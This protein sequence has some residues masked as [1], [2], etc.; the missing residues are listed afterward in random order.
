MRLCFALLALLLPAA[1]AEI[2][3]L[4]TGARIRADRIERDGAKLVLHDGPGRIELDAA[5]VSAIEHEPDP[6]PAASSSATTPLAPSAPKTARELVTAAALRHGLPPEFVHSV[7]ATESAYN[8]QALSPKGA[9]GVMQLM[10]ATARYLDADPHDLEQNI[11]AGTRL[12]RDLLLKYQNDP[13]PVSRALAA[14]NAGEGAVQ[15][16]N[17]IPPYRE[18]QVYI[19]RV[20]NRY[21]NQVG[22]PPKPKAR[23]E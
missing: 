11:D 9:V 15:R 22:G 12:L 5:L 23:A 10:P 17:G 21:W 3:V 7:A 2:A 13:N 4:Q 19:D 6:E 8:P 16:Y 18:T 1:A 20:L 14:Y